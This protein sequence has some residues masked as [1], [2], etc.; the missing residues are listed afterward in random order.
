MGLRGWG[1]E[2][3]G[4]SEGRR[5]QKELTQKSK[6]F[7]IHGIHRNIVNK[8]H[9][10]AKWCHIAHKVQGRVCTGPSVPAGGHPQ[11]GESRPRPGAHAWSLGRRHNL[12]LGGG[13]DTP[14]WAWRRC[15]L[16]PGQLEGDLLESGG[17]LIL[18][19]MK[20]II[21]DPWSSEVSR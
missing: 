4:S 5:G 9:V 16:G 11:P 6:Q 21:G 15:H 1:W 19:L 14:M 20:K 12:G 2:E 13:K 7:S 3:R 8:V 10:S 17:N 18:D